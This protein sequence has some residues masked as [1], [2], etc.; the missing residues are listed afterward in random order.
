MPRRRGDVALGS[1]CSPGQQPQRA[2]TARGSPAL[3]G[4]QPRAGAAVSTLEFTSPLYPKAQN[5][6]KFE[7]VFALV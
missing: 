4:A 7:I 1:C 2:R 3:L 5:L 6:S